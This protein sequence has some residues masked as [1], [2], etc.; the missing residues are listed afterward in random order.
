MSGIFGG[1][2]SIP[3]PIP[4]ILSTLDKTKYKEI[5]DLK[6]KKKEKKEGRSN[7]DTVSEGGVY[8]QCPICWTDF[9]RHHLVTPLPCNAKH[10]YHSS[11]I[12]SW[13]RKGYNSCPL[14]RQNIADM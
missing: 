5:V 2:I 14:C 8:K 13:I 1:L 10:I 4:E 6:D 9:K 7:F 11:C 3:L 12:E